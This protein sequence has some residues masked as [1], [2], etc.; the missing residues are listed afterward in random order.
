MV[1]N[2]TPDGQFCAHSGPNI[3]FDP[4]SGRPD[5]C[6]TCGAEPGAKPIPP[7]SDAWVVTMIVLVGFFI[8]AAVSF[9]VLMPDGNS[10]E[11]HRPVHI[12]QRIP[13][14]PSGTIAV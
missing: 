12:P 14:P 2:P 6:A 13:F 7:V 8:L 10:G 9:F 1:R 3:V 5:R 4:V 11:P